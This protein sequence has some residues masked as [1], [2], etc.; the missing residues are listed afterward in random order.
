MQTPTYQPIDSASFVM[1]GVL[2]R[3]TIL[4]SRAMSWQGISSKSR[5]QGR[6]VDWLLHLLWVADI[7]VE[8][9]GKPWSALEH[10]TLQ[11]LKEHC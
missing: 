1:V 8:S 4:P 3:V 11:V 2:V 7:F 9:H 6:R 5:L 10:S